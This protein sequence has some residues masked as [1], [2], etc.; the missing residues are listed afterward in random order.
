MD[1]KLE[2]EIVKTFIE[3]K[4]RQRFLEFVSSPKNRDKVLYEINSPAVFNQDLITEIK[5]SERTP[6]RL[7]AKYKEL[8]MGGRVYVISANGDWDGQK[9][10]MSYIV[11]ECLAMGIDTIGFCWKTKTAFYEWHHSGASY[12][13]RKKN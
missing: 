9:F 7:V 5:G 1:K 3:P 4:R 11:G 13:L 2:I 12:F 6:E 10:Q 8:G